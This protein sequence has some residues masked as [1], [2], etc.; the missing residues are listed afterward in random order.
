MTGPWYTGVVPRPARP[1]DAT[2]LRDI[3]RA[4]EWAAAHRL[5]RLTLTSFAEVPW[6]R[7][8]YERLGF[9][10]LTPDRLGPELRR[11]RAQEAELGL[12]RWP[13]VAMCPPVDVAGSPTRPHA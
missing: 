2:R 12:D 3:D 9:R 10:V 1:D 11:L 5:P 6:N 13:R 4:G 7:A 8:S